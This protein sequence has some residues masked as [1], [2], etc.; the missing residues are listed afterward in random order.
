MSPKPLI[1]T[2][3]GPTKDPRP[4]SPVGAL[5]IRP[6][7]PADADAIERLA[8][9]DSTRAPRGEI[10]LAEVRDEAWAAVSVDDVHAVADPF[11][12]TSELVWLLVQRA[13]DI[14]R[15]R[16][17]RRRARRPGRRAVFA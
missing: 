12:P 1:R 7:T 5:T 9:L 14:N 11:R 17:P 3:T 16:R 10:L 6:A 4:T 15:D 2:L 8:A 13:R